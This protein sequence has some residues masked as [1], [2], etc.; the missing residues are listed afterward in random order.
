MMS[1]SEASLE[2]VKEFTK[3]RNFSKFDEERIIFP[4][5]E[6]A[7]AILEEADYHIN[8]MLESDPRTNAA[9]SSEEPYFDTLFE[10]HKI[11]DKYWRRIQNREIFGIKDSEL[12]DCLADP[13]IKLIKYSESDKFS[14]LPDNIKNAIAV[15][16]ENLSYAVKSVNKIEKLDYNSISDKHH[17]EIA[18]AC[19]DVLRYIKKDLLEMCL[20]SSKLDMKYH[21]FEEAERNMIY[22]L[23]MP[24]DGIETEED[25]DENAM[26]YLHYYKEHLL[27]DFVSSIMD[28]GIVEVSDL[29]DFI[30][31]YLN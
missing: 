3:G 22:S 26:M 27:N 19:G 31:D 9:D 14:A 4:L 20:E 16:E 17:T 15:A 29:K 30:K 7:L 10:I 21:S 28:S 8:V 12:N 25:R 6:K 1:V 13:L 18:R 5:V 11:I 23:S 2:N 24:Y